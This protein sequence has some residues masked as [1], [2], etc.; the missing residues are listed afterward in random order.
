MGDQTRPCGYVL[1]FGDQQMNCRYICLE[2]GIEM[3]IND[4]EEGEGGDVDQGLDGKGQ[5]GKVAEWK[6]RAVEA[7]KPGAASFTNL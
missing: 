7:V 3:E 1:A 5:K 6:K 2:W 4:C